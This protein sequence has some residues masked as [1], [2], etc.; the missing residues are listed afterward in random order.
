M[1]T[2][3]R[4]EMEREFEAYQEPGRVAGETGD[5]SPWADQFTEDAVYLEHLYG[6]FEGREAIRTWITAR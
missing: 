5:W 3:S 4:A 6:R 2:F 1:P